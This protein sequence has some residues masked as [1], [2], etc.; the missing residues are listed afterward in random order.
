MAG[1]I[2]WS[3]TTPEHIQSIQAS[4]DAIEEHLRNIHTHMEALNSENKGR[5]TSE[6]YASHQTLNTTGTQQV[7][8]MRQHASN[9]LSAF[10]AA[11]DQ[12]AANSQGVS[13]G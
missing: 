6:M 5:T 13:L 12:D 9:T 10:N 3:P 4:L 8:T 11:H 7:E 2:I 1:T